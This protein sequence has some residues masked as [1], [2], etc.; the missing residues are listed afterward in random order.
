ME[1]LA[2]LLVL[3][4]LGILVVGMYV[5]SKINPRPIDRIKDLSEVFP[6]NGIESGV[7]ISGKG[8]LTVGFKVKLPDVFCMSERDADS[9]HNDFVSI[10]RLLPEGAVV[11]KQDFFYLEKNSKNLEGKNIIDKE[12]KRLFSGRPRLRS[13]SYLYL[14]VANRVRYG[15]GNNTE[16]QASPNYLFKEPAWLKDYEKRITEFNKMVDTFQNALNGVVGIEAERLEDEELLERIYRFVSMEF[17]GELSEEDKK[18]YRVSPMSVDQ[19]GHL[20]IGKYFV[21]VLTLAEES[22]SLFNQVIPKTAPSAS[23]GNGVGYSNTIKSKTSFVFPLG[24]GLPIDHVLNTTIQILDNDKVMQ[25]L[26]SENKMLSF[27]GNF[28]PPA[29]VKQKVVDGFIDTILNKNY[30]VCSTG[31]NVIL[32]E[33]DWDAME[34]SLSAAE[35]AFMNMGRSKAYVENFD[36][37]NIF[38]SMIPGNAE[39]NYREFIN[40]TAQAVCYINKE[41]MVKGDVNG[42]LFTDRFG[43]PVVVDMWNNANADNRN[44]LVFGPS[45]S[46]KS[47]WVNN[48]VNQTLDH[49][50]HIIIIDIGHS[51]KRNVAF[52]GGKY[53]NSEDKKSLS[54]NL[55][56]CRKDD[57]GN[58]IYKDTEDEEAKDDKVNMIL[59]VLL[60]I[61]KGNG[62]VDVL[63]RTLFKNSICD[64]YE[65]VNEKKI[66]ANLIGYSEFLTE[67]EN[68][69]SREHKRVFRVS[70]IQVI[71]TPFVKGE[72]QNLLNNDQGTDIENE[73]L[74]VF[75]M[76]A[77]QND[78]TI[79]PIMVIIIIELLISKMNKFKGERKSLLIDEGLNF[80]Q[81][82]V[83]G[84]YIG[85]SYRTIRKK[86][87]EIVLIAQNGL[88]IQS[89]AEEV[90][91]S[92][93]M[94]TSTHILL[95]HSQHK[96]NYNTIQEL[97]SFT[98]H[99][100][101]MLDSLEKTDKYREFFMKIGSQ[102]SVYRLEV[103]EF[104]NAVYTSKE[105]EITEIERLKK[106][107]GSYEAAINQYVEN[108]K[109]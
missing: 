106:E 90:R 63:E 23:Y 79:F 92:I 96:S 67:Y 56:H 80:L 39:A 94:N 18:N 76:E 86:G 14:S 89:A 51:Y 6:I 41:G 70:D 60:K 47:F 1:Y 57:E 8:D 61:V 33:K 88:F 11:H 98:D 65:Y 19:K 100:I 30:Q 44:K 73:K 13:E 62:K 24:C 31:V 22:L 40:T 26:R 3:S 66:K 42:I 15:K 95:D 52:K 28:Y 107:K 10:L 69:L 72:Y 85:Y 64:Y 20:N 74:V 27:L 34:I 82:E 103:S 97:L 101:E 84:G 99:H 102:P 4:I 93:F 38:F 35:V 54:F 55:F 25:N 45:G 109:K 83:M 9:M 68:R 53:F 59:T 2:L 16:L 50:N 36:T 78:V 17:D 37:A 81:D 71:L 5:L 91:N 108:K 46:G 21:K 77:I 105:E 49:G 12:N 7:I 87:G 104:A 43:N 29:G 75:D 32:R 58:Y 48:Y